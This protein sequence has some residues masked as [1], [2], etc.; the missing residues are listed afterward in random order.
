MD[1]LHFR[2]RA[3]QARELARDGEDMRLTQLL[4]ALADDMDAEAEAMDANDERSHAASG[5]TLTL[6]RGQ[7]GTVR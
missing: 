3:E 6:S 2:R 4:L 7:T 5:S 1:A